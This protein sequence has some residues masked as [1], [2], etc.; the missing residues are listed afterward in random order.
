VNLPLPSH[1]LAAPSQPPA[2]P[3][4]AL[5]WR[6]RYGQLPPASYTRLAPTPVPEPYP[7]AYS[8]EAAALIGLR[9]S[10]FTDETLLHALAG[11][12]EVAGADPLA[13]VYSGHQFG[14]YVPR[15]GDGRAH[16]LGG[17]AGP[18]HQTWELQLKGSGKTPYSR[19]GDG[20][21]VLRSSVR[22]FLC[23]EAMAALGIPTTRA[24]AVVGSDLPVFREGVETAAVT[25]RMAPSFVRFGSFEYFYWTNQHAELRALADHVIDAFYP[26]CPD[27]GSGAA[28]YLAFLA[29]VVTR[30]A[31]LLAQWQA[32]GFCHGVMNTDN[33]SILGL[34]ID[35][36]P[37]GFM[38]GFDAGH[39]CN[40][41]DDQ[42]RYAYNMQP[43]IAHWNLYCLGQAL[44]PLI[45]DLDATQAVLEQYRDE[46]SRAMDDAFHAKL[47]LAQKEEGDDTLISSVLELLHAQRVDWTIFWRKLA[48]L[49]AQAGEPAD[50]APVRDLFADRAAF[51]AWAVRYRARLAQEASGDAARA[52]AMNRINPKYVLRNHLAEVAIRKARG[53]DGAPRDTSEIA[54]LHQVLRRPFDEQPQ[55]EAY[56]QQPP[57]WAA[58]LHLSCSS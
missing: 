12:V 14:V 7:V 29:H 40:H 41:S 17:V 54:R 20:R 9:A 24:L 43:G 23:S 39:I 6:N 32:V 35:Y 26:D 33:M 48:Q 22:E 10:I 58:S 31:R 21:A 57:D 1:V 49:R 2:Q 47:G 15:L 34:T 55:F 56:A 44:M 28:R 27:A 45:D 11:N 52:Q 18:D 19:M 25:T 13:A 3:L 46:Y 50:D 53:D 16:L 38:D 37:Y 30:T 42:G 8:E 36:G 4:S 51:D 5:R